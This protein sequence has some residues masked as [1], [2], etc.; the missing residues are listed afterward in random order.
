M[1]NNDYEQNQTIIDANDTPE[2]N[3]K[4]FAILAYFGIFWI[5]GLVATPEKDHPFVKNHVNN[6]ITLFI[7]CAILAII[8]FLGWLLEIAICVFAI[9]GIIAA[10]KG[11][12]YT[13]PFVGDKIQ[14]IK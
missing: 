4:L 9:M 14:I 1:E 3:D 5:I 8:P 10:A 7:G 12:K 13:I 2:G 6:G 11:E